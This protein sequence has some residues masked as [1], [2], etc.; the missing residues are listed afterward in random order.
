MAFVLSVLYL[1]VG[2]K[3]AGLDITANFAVPSASWAIDPQIIVHYFC[4]FVCYFGIFCVLSAA[5]LGV[6]G[7]WLVMSQELLH[8]YRR[9]GRFLGH[10]AEP[11]ECQCRDGRRNHN[12][13]VRNTAPEVV[14]VE[15]N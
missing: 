5:T 14:P 11:V 4:T 9:R 1:L 2:A 15:K 12:P 8:E 10:K 6:C 13:S 3:L 7:C